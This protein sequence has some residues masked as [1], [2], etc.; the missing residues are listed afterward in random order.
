MRLYM[1]LLGNRGGSRLVRSGAGAGTGLDRQRS[2]RA[3]MCDRLEADGPI[4]DRGRL[5]DRKDATGR[6]VILQCRWSS[7]LWR[8]RGL[9]IGRLPRFFVV[10]REEGRCDA[11]R[12]P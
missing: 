11:C 6:L 7:M 9:M 1:S 12:V 3:R 10:S 8:E 5:E 4:E 2:S